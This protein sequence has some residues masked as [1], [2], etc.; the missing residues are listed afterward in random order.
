MFF[1]VRYQSISSGNG[2]KPEGETGEIRK[3]KSFRSEFVVFLV[4]FFVI[5]LF[6]YILTRLYPE[7]LVRAQNFVAKEVAWCLSLLKHRF[8][9]VDSTFTFY[10]PHG[11]ERLIV[12]AECTGV[13]TTIIYLSIVAAYPARIH[14]KLIG[15][16]MGVPAIHLLNLARMVFVS[17]VL[18]HKRNLF[19]FF[20]GY[21][22]QVVFVIFM[23]LLVIFWM[24]RIVR[25]RGVTS[26][27]GEPG[28]GKP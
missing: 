8:S 11:G 24:T 6:S 20:H 2:K 28:P 19:K 26:A 17:L 27:R 23:L 10:T 1:N 18:F 25:P 3:V 5:W 14:E 4:L 13:Y 16:V 22:W 9:L 7:F 15:L 21:L 12:I